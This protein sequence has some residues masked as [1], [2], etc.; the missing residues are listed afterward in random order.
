[1]I[2]INTKVQNPTGLHARPS[3]ILVMN[4]IKFD[5]NI[6]FKAKGQTID[7]K[8]LLPLVSL[9]LKCGDDITIAADGSDE[10]EAV[11]FLSEILD[12]KFGEV[13]KEENL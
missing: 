8:V 10:K 9:K 4:A 3:A 2:E 12:T 1:M 11:N 5:S 6:W 7:A 13:D